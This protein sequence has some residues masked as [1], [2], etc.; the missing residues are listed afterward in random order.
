M[1]AECLGTTPLRLT[2]QEDIGACVALEGE[3]R[4]AL[5]GTCDSR[6]DCIQDADFCG[7]FGEEP[8]PICTRRCETNA[9]ATRFLMPYARPFV[10]VWRFV[11]SRLKC[12]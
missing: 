3:G 8:L 2:C 5:G 11:S 12:L 4:I 7:Q 1:G 10:V 9:S 6:D